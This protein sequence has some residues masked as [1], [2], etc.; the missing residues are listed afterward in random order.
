LSAADQGLV[1]QRLIALPFGEMGNM[2]KTSV[3]FLNLLQSLSRSLDSSVPVGEAANRV[4]NCFVQQMNAVKYDRS[5]GDWV[6]LESGSG[7][8]TVKK[9]RLLL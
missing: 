9:L 6:V 3:E 7:V 8:S 1:F 2:G 5:N 4:M